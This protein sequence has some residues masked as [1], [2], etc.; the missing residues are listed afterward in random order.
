MEFRDRAGN[1]IVAKQRLS[2]EQLRADFSQVTF[3]SFKPIAAG[4]LRPPGQQRALGAIRLA[5]GMRRK[6]FNLFVSGQAGSGRH[7]LVRSVL[8]EEGN[9]KDLPS[10]WVY[11][12]NFD[13]P[14]KPIALELPAGKARHFKCAMEELIDD[15]ANDIPANFESEAYQAQRKSI[16]QEFAE[17]HESAFDALVSLATERGLILLRTP[18]GFMVA[19]EKDGKPMKPEEFRA[20]PEPEQAKIDKSISEVQGELEKVLKAIPQREKEHRKAVESLNAEIAQQSVDASLG[21]VEAG[22]AGL[23]GV[24]NYLDRVRADLTEN[25]ALF[26]LDERAPQAGAFPVSTTKHYLKPQFARYSVNAIIARSDEAEGGVPIIEE[27]LPSLPN[28]I[29][30]IEHEAEMGTLVT[31]FTMIKAG[32]L[33]RANGGYLILD[34]IDIVSEPFAW[35]ALKRCLKTEAIKITS[36]QERLSL[37]TT[38]SLDPDPIPL[39]VRIILIGERMIF[40]LLSLLDPEFPELFKVHA[41]FEDSLNW[42][43]EALAAFAIMLR[44]LAA[45]ED[46]LEAGHISGPLPRWGIRCKIERRH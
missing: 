22:F 29:G 6:G 3:A 21:E 24:K 28:L 18:M 13:Q 12:N 41:D 36:L 31:N 35:D 7:E 45:Q 38:T 33:H 32:A 34:A 15:L 4:A 27:R 16:E 23:P 1:Q 26:L 9:L 46:C 39:S 2:I 17:A 42:T 8:R 25:A 44:G 20:L 43:D 5:V 19:A 30:R 14:E 11:L 40:Y 10:D 37:I